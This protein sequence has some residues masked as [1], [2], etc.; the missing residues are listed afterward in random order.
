MK[1][2]LDPGD[3]KPEFQEKKGD[4]GIGQ[5][6]NTRDVTFD[7]LNRTAQVAVEAV[8]RATFFAWDKQTH[9]AVYPRLFT[10]KLCNATTTI[11]S[12]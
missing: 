2:E 1:L 3:L 4:N 11:M 8:G 7:K 6:C 12:V 9:N 5:K 10:R